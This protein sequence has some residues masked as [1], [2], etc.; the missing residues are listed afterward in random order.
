MVTD[1]AKRKLDPKGKLDARGKR[2]LAEKLLAQA[3][4]GRG[5]G[6]NRQVT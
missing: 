2:A 3:S 1:Q 6:V 4:R 5:Q